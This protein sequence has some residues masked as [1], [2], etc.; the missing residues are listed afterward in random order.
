MKNKK[1]FIDF[2]SEGN[3]SSE[4]TFFENAT[5]HITNISS[6]KTYSGTG[7]TNGVLLLLIQLFGFVDIVLLSAYM[8]LCVFDRNR[9]EKTSEFTPPRS[10]F[11]EPNFAYENVEVVSVFSLS[12]N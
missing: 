9:Q 10:N 11:S 1:H 5:T 6:P 3:V 2:L 4:I 12:N 7:M 8:F